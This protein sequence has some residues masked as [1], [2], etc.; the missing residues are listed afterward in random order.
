MVANAKRPTSRS[1]KSRPRISAIAVF[2]D[3]PTLAMPCGMC[4]QV[5]AEFERDALVIVANPRAERVLSFA[6]LFPEPFVLEP[7]TPGR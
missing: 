2:T 7:E 6:E 1:A 3:A 4:R 5:L